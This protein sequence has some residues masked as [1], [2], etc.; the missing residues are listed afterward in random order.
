MSPKIIAH[1][2]SRM[3]PPIEILNDY[4][5]M[6]WK[7]EQAAALGMRVAIDEIIKPV[8]KTLGEWKQ[9]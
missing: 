2:V 5:K 6:Q 1:I 3:T 9:Y 4:A 7:L 8:N